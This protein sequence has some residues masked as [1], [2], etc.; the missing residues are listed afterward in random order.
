LAL[1]APAPS[2]ASEDPEQS[3]W[4]RADSVGRTAFDL[5][6]LRPLQLVQVALSAA[7]FVPAYPVS[8]LFDAGEDVLEICIS[9][10][11]ERAFRRPLG[12]L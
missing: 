5:V 7:V 9:E 8:L 6:I 4:A 12:D 10:P 2:V 1:L 11:V 3:G